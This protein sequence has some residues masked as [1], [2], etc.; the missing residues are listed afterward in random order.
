MEVWS[1]IP[2]GGMLAPKDL[3]DRAHSFG[4]GVVRLQHAAL[5]SL[6]QGVH[7]R[8]ESAT[9]DPGVESPCQGILIQD[10]VRAMSA[11]HLRLGV[12]HQGK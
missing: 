11:L 12:V 6:S 3:Q 2:H 4:A 9:E 1:R 5:A 10:G 8:P 7:C